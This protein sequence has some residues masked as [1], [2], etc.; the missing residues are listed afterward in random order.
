M[1]IQHTLSKRH[2]TIPKRRGGGIPA[3]K[4][5]NVIFTPLY[6]YV[7]YRVSFKNLSN[8]D[9]TVVPSDVVGVPSECNLYED[10]SETLR[11]KPGETENFMLNFELKEKAKSFSQTDFSLSL[12]I[13]KTS[14]WENSSYFTYSGSTITGMNTSSTYSTDKPRCIVMPESYGGNTITA[15]ADGTEATPTFQ[16]LAAET[17]YVVMADSIKTLGSYAFWHIDSIKS[18]KFSNNL[19]AMKEHAGQARG[20]T[21]VT[22]P[23]TVKTFGNSLFVDDTKLGIITI[24]EDSK[25]ESM[26][27]Y[28]MANC[29]WTGVYLPNGL[30]TILANALVC[31]RAI[32]IT[33]PASVTDMG[34][35]YYYGAD[36]AN[37]KWIRFEGSSLLD[38]VS[39]L[40]I[41]DNSTIGTK[42]WVR[43]DSDDAP[44][45][46]AST[47]KEIPA[48][49]N[50]G[51]YHR[52]SGYTA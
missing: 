1:I 17:K 29:A 15:T 36:F 27:Y 3:W 5:E 38:A 49:G 25:L 30:R 12:D 10:S 32:S 11:I 26:G 8:S 28:A 14:E 42:T 44:T 20:L 22:I 9:I 41:N 13:R 16:K 50:A 46:W 4:P 52:K 33:I 6:R 35:L 39:L 37:L 2:Q 43:T 24:P 40:P 45:S 7:Q 23:S 34:I 21:A 48:T 51:Y 31:P 18:I 19:E 47:V